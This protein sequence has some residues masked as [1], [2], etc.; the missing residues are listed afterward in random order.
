MTLQGSG[1]LGN[2]NK[3]EMTRNTETQGSCRPGD[4]WYALQVKPRHERVVSELLSQKGLQ[5]LS[6]VYASRRTWSDRIQVIDLP[7]FPCY[8]FAQFDASRPAAVITTPGL[9]RIV[10]V[11]R[12]PVPVEHYEIENLRRAA[13]S[14]AGCH[15]HP[16][17]ETGDVVDVISGPMRDT[18]GV[19][20]QIRG[21]NRLVVAVTLLNRSVSVELDESW[22]IKRRNSNAA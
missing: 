11:G 9:V 20:M 21:Q 18:R 4:P 2:Q 8:V 1:N 5:S 15:P 17:L 7:L 19:L 22:V 14:G 16:G 12:Q 3:Q 13:A 10:G 6:P